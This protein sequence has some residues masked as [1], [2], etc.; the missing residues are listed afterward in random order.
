M[1]KR[2]KKRR[3]S[4]S[5]RSVAA[6]HRYPPRDSIQR[7]MCVCRNGEP[8]PH[9]VLDTPVRFAIDWPGYF[10]IPDSHFVY[11]DA[12]GW[13]IAMSNYPVK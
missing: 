5:L 9:R 8:Q 11:D 1:S 12:G 13:I 2:Q 4:N 6:K 7:A 10:G 3:P